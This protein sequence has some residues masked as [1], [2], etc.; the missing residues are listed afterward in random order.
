M[1]SCSLVAMHVVG[2]RP[3]RYKAANTGSAQD[4]MA[5]GHLISTDMTIHLWPKR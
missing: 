1:D 4:W 3:P 2:L 5:S